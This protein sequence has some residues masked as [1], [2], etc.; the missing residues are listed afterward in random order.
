MQVVKLIGR[1]LVVDVISHIYIITD[2]CCAQILWMKQQ[3]KDFGILLYH[4]TLRCDNTS[5]INL[6]KNLVMHS[7]TNHIEIKHRFIR[8]HVLKCDYFINF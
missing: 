1:V 2:S 6:T 8:D 5:A 7:R 3:L 4:I